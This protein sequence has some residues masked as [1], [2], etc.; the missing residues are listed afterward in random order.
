MPASKTPRATV[1]RVADALD[2]I[3]PPE[4][5]QS[6]DNVGLLT[7]DRR[8]ACPRILL[9]VDLTPPVLAEAVTQR[10]ALIVAYH[11]PLFRPIKRILAGSA[12]L[13]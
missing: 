3:A 4:L 6:W 8:A 9:C 1:G 5:A 12:E 7:G 10:C 2:V 13:V 11:P